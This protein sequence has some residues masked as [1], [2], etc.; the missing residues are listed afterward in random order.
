MK[1]S[2]EGVVTSKEL[3]TKMGDDNKLRISTELLIAQ[4]GEKVQATV[5]LEGNQVKDYEIFQ[6]AVFTGSLMTWKTR[7]GVGMMIMVRDDG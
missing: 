1:V 4:P 7:D 6:P 5:R 3:K 2:V